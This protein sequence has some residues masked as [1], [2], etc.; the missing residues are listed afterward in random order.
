[1]P[2]TKYP[3][4]DITQETWRQQAACQYVEPTIFFPES[5]HVDAYNE[6]IEVCQRCPV[7]SECLQHATDNHESYGVWGGKLFERKWKK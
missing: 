3:R 1:M 7:R 2:E 4:T 5:V 6:A